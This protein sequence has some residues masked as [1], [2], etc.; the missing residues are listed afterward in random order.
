VFVNKTARLA[1]HDD[2]KNEIG[3]VPT[4]N[5]QNDAF[6]ICPVQIGE[7]PGAVSVDLQFDTGSADLWGTLSGFSLTTVWSSELDSSISREGRHV[8]DPRKSPKAKK[9][10]GSSWAIT[11]GDGSFASGDIYSVASYAS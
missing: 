2:N 4:E 1:V 11:Y 9:M 7:G 8:Y 3:E 10:E 5:F 6:Y